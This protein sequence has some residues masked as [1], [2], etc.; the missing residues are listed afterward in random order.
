MNTNLEKFITFNG[1]K[2]VLLDENG[3]WLVAIRPICEALGVNFDRQYKN[4]KKSKILGQLYAEQHMV[5]ADGRIRNMICLPELFIYGWLFQ[6]ESNAPGLEE[7]QWECYKALFGHFRGT[8]TGRKDLL[9]DRA[10]KMIKMARLENKV[11]VSPE[12]KELDA[13]KRQCKAIDRNLK[14]LDNDQLEKE[15]ALF[16]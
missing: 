3:T 6:I 16:K 15:L 13:L 8:I 4:L 14:K 12:A 5:A 2:I 10:E 7:Y 11:F 1:K 9:K